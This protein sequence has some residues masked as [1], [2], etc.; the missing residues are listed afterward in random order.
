MGGL[1]AQRTEVPWLPLTP[2]LWKAFHRFPYAS[3]AGTPGSMDCKSPNPI[4]IYREASRR[5]CLSDE[6]VEY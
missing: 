6:Q 2:F 5:V 3:L 4:G 1:P